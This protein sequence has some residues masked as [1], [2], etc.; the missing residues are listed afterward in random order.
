MFVQYSLMK[1]DDCFDAFQHIL[2][3]L[4]IVFVITASKL[5]CEKS[6]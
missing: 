4:P 6:T 5:K 2:Q 1:G 3:A